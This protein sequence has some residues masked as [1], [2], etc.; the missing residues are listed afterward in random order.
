MKPAEKTE[1]LTHK[2]MDHILMTLLESLYIR[3]TKHLFSPYACLNS[4]YVSCK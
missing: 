1:N 2:E 4:F 3:I